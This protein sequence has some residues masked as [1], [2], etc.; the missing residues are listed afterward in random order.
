MLNNRILLPP[1]KTGKV[2]F[3]GHL[4]VLAGFLAMVASFGTLYCFGVFFKPV[5]AQFGW[6]RAETSAA[7]SLY[8]IIHGMVNII[9][10]R[11]VD[12]FNPRL[13][14]AICGIFL[15][16]G[17]LLMSQITALWQYYLF[18]SVLVGTGMTVY[19]PFF[20][21]VA[22]SFQKR[23]GLMTGV[24]A[25][26]IG[27]GTVIMPPIATQLIS[28]YDWST[29][30][31]II[32]CFVLVVIVAAAFFISSRTANTS[33]LSNDAGAA[34]Q[35]I[36][37]KTP[38]FTVRAAIHTRQFWMFGISLFSFMFVQQVVVVHIIPYATDLGISAVSAASIISFIGGLSI[39]GRLGL[40]GASD[41]V[42]TKAAW[43]IAL[44]S[45][46]ISLFW[47]FLGA[48]ELWGFYLFAVIFGFGYGGGAVL[49]S[50]MIANLFGLRWHGAIYGMVLFIAMIGGAVGPLIAGGIFDIS[51]NYQIALLITAAV[52]VMG[53]ALA[54]VL[55]LHGRAHAMR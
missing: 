32:G 17:Y 8:M 13:V 35:T 55:R 34:A 28:S 36:N 10:G 52:G 53:L 48:R 39:T 21:T 44:T 20:S 42:G 6:T 18:Y 46:A 26:G 54:L 16:S 14:V 19:L 15:G 38:G 45:V 2:R 4:M 1:S 33:E 37:E 27:V 22:K 30:Y 5:S 51:G 12:R 50:P 40:G 31:I 29:S 7:Y 49:Q 25:S 23:R 47:L 3:P 24:V 43:L 9:I 11:M 41:R